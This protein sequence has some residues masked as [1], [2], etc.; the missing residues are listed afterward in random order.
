MQSATKTAETPL[1]K[2]D[3]I[4]DSGPSTRGSEL[5]ALSRIAAW[6][7]DTPSDLPPG[8]ARLHTGAKIGYSLWIVVQGIYA[9]IFWFLGQPVL[10]AFY[11][12]VT[13]LTA[14]YL[15]LLVT[16][17]GAP[18]FIMA[19]T[20]NLTGVWLV[21]V[22]TGLDGG[23]FLFALV[24]LLYATLAAWV[25][26]WVQWLISIASAL[27]F[28]AVVL[29][30]LTIPP[31]APIPAT[32]VL[33]FATVNGFGT[34]CFLLM[35]ALTYRSFVDKAEAALEA[36]YDKSEALLHNIMPPSVADRL[37]QNPDVI[38]DS[39][40]RVTIL[41]ADIVGFTDMAGRSSPEELVTLL[42]AIFSRFDALVEERGLEKIKTI[43]DAYMVVAGLPEA[44]DDHAQAI[45]RLALSMVD[46]TR[47]VSDEMGQALQIRIGVHSGKVV[48]GVIGQKKFAY[49]LWGDTVNVAARMESHGEPG[50]I[51]VSGDTAALL[52]D[53]FELEAR[54][55]IEV[56]GKGRMTAYFLNGEAAPDPST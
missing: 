4:A 15:H 6:Y 53:G 9:G 52:E 17:R 2:S 44:R 8:E 50:R 21:T 55:E 1:S 11:L 24:G 30:G 49:D 19:N 23:F 28:V 47:A 39:H 31:L 56:K 41:F 40:S 5:T 34:V 18:A 7:T 22:Y 48:A 25:S 33:I 42:N 36:E 10:A 37:K 46:A 12:A 14:L 51:Q 32:W 13:L 20:H 26:R 35:V 54:G 29:Y 27:T 16:R 38:A 43:G 45:A 3:Q